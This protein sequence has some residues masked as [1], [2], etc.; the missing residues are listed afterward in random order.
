MKSKHYK[1]LK[2]KNSN[3]FYCGTGDQTWDLALAR[4]AL[5]LLSYLRI[6]L[7]QSFKDCDC[8]SQGTRGVLLRGGRLGVPAPLTVCARA[9]HLMGC[10]FLA[11]QRPT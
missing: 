11:D 7:G 2:P 9:C 5:M 1:G 8:P 10:A 4:E 3:F 6:P